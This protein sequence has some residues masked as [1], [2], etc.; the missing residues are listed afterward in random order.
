MFSDPSVDGPLLLLARC[1][2]N[3]AKEDDIS[4]RNMNVDD[5]RPTSRFAKFQTALTLQRVVGFSVTANRTAP[6]TVV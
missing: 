1:V 6:L 5:R 2:V 4:V 3:I